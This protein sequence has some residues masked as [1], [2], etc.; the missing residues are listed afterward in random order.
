MSR[1]VSVIGL[2]KLGASMAASIASRGHDVIGVDISQAAVDAVNQGRAPVQETGL[3]DLITANHARLRATQ[4]GAVP[5]KS[6]VPA[7]LPFYNLTMRS[8]MSSRV[9]QAPP[10]GVVCLCS[11]ILE[12]KS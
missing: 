5:Q 12:R 1:R 8:P 10:G 4:V 3:A 6:H 7:A 9:L 2:G 11:P